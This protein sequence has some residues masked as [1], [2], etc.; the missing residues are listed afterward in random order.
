M[1]KLET[2]QVDPATGTTLTLGT[3]GDTISIPSGVTIA[4][5]GT[6]TGFGGANTP[7][8]LVRRSSDQSISDASGTKVQFNSEVYDSASAF[9]SSSNYRFT[10]PSGQA[11]K[12]YF[13]GTLCISSEG[14]STNVNSQVYIYKNGSIIAQYENN[15]SD[16]N[17]RTQVIPYTYS[18]SLSVGDYIEVYGYC[19]TSDNASP[20]IVGNS[21]RH[22]STFGGY[23]IIE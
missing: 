17:P 2:N 16:N 7:N 19:N 21:T 8:F 11:G 5:S 3:S 15:N 22:K 20:A 1:S 6:A 14:D 12:Y 23:K 10:V 9:D 18:E 13:Y 4:N